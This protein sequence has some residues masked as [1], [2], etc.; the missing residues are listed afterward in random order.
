M[1]KW[2]SFILLTLL[3]VPLF[4]ANNFV[5]STYP[6]PDG[7]LIDRITVPGIPVEQRVPGPVAVPTRSTVMLGGVPAFD[8]SYGCSATSAAMMAGYY[9]RRNF[10]HVYMGPTNDGIMP[11]NNSTWGAGECPLSA[12]HQGYDGL[13]TAGHVDRFWTN[14]AGD[15][16]F[17]TGNPTSTYYGCTADYM[18][19]NQQ[20][21]GNIDG[22]TTFANY[23]DG[24]ALYDPQDGITGPPYFRDGVHGLRLF[25]ES[26][27]YSI[28]TN[29]NQYIYGWEGNTIGYTL[30][31]YKASI[32]AGIPVMIQIQGHSMVGIGYETTSST[33][34]VLNT[35]D[36]SIHTMT[37]G[38]EYSGMLHYGVSV[39]Q[40][41][42]PPEISVDADTIYA[43]LLTGEEGSDG[44]TISNWG[45]GPLSY[46]L[47]LETLR[48]LASTD[49]DIG[50]NDRNISGSTLVVDATDYSPGTTVD[51]TFTVHNASTD[52][53]WLKYIDITFPPGITINSVSNFV[54]GGGGEMSPD[55]RMGEDITIQWNN[56]PEGWGVIYMNQTALAIVNVTIS[57]AFE[58]NIALPFVITGDIY[59]SDP[60][61]IS[62]TMDIAQRPPLLPWFDIVPL[63]G[64]IPAGT[65]RSVTANFSAIGM[66]PGTY[67]AVLDVISNDPYMPI[68]T[69]N[70]LLEVRGG[71][72][73]VIYSIYKSSRGTSI[74]WD[75]VPNAFIYNVYRSLDPYGFFEFLTSTTLTTFEDIGT[76]ERYFYR[77]TAEY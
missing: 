48:S 52:D 51:W 39:L 44:F 76:S 31:Q 45:T 7:R 66:E 22:S 68:Y 38:G 42:E 3:F 63:N 17:G 29:Y 73:P 56:S 8:W 18:G 32:D 4:A 34:Y 13:A 20:W 40:L 19:T 54:G 67:E 64:V 21:W 59:G 65:N 30:D 27:G 26:R 28:S 1:S 25:F 53:E 41:N 72:Y 60:H 61:I 12:T 35:W 69:L 70:V 74:A 77:V 62:G 14:N 49:Q 36:Y 24:S 75:G 10:G 2:F 23:V 50:N 55:I 47:Q 58:G 5:V 15:D 37:W 46:S 71:N 6:G 33:I 43:S 9:D 11:L 57:P 16:P